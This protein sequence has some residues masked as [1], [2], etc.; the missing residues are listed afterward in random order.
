MVTENG[1]ANERRPAPNVEREVS[2]FG[3][4]RSANFRDGPRLAPDWSV[5]HFDRVEYVARGW[6]L[7]GDL[8]RELVMT[9]T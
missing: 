7:L 5:G 2:L 8:R 1:P 6:R 3:E 4:L 9:P